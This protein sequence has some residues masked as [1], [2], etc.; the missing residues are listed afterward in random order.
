MAV[1]QMRELQEKL[2]SLFI[3]ILRDPA[4][5]EICLVSSETFDPSVRDATD[6]LGPDWRAREDALAAITQGITQAGSAGLRDEL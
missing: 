4:G 2:G 6:Y 3:V 1:W 5:F